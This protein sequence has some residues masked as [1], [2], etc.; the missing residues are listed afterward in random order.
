MILRGLSRVIST[1]LYLSLVISTDFIYARARGLFRPFFVTFPIRRTY[2]SGMQTSDD[3]QLLREFAASQSE[4]AFA[5]LVSRY[6]NLVYSAALRQAANPHDAEEIAQAVFLV[7]ARKASALRPAWFC[8]LLYQT[9]RL[10]AANFIRGN[11]RRQTREQEAYMESTA[12]EPDAA[13]WTQI[14]P[15]L[16]EAMARLNEK[17]RNA[18]CP[19]LFEEKDM[20]AIAAALGSSEDAAKMRL[21]RA[22]D[23]LREYLSNAAS[24]FP[25]QAGRRHF[26]FLRASRSRRFGGLRYYGN[27]RRHR[28]RSTLNTRERN[29]TMILGPKSILASRRGDCRPSDINGTKP[30]SLISAPRNFEHLYVVLTTETFTERSWAGN[31]NASGRRGLAAPLTMSDRHAYEV[32]LTQQAG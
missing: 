12:N 9:A 26:R 17:D 30:P 15:L 19:A 18:V 27:L 14:A 10:T 2:R 13:S 1:H 7:L 11:F 5:T 4:E 25:A 8:R 20:S 6:I 32:R 21:S 16:D 31:K 24:P 22:L 3:M 29:S 28:R 23:K